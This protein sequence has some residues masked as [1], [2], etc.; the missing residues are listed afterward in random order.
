MTIAPAPIVSRPSLAPPPTKGSRLTSLLRTTDHKTIGLM[1]MVASFGF[2]MIG[3]LMRNSQTN[4]IDRAPGLGNVPILGA[5]FRSTSDS[6]KRTNLLIF[7]TPRIVTDMK[8][9]EQ[10]KARLERA[11]SLQGAETTLDEPDPAAEKA[12]E[13]AKAERAAQKA[14]KKKPRLGGKR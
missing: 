8:M 9:A 6:K 5:L 14:E 13:K 12:A 1:Y 4:S 3:G 10:E 2:F 11:T 7:V